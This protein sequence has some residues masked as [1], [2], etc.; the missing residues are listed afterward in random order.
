M[1]KQ[2][3]DNSRWKENSFEF[4][5]E[6]TEEEAQKLQEETIDSLGVSGKE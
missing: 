4:V 3:K 1:A 5:S 6:S 2:E